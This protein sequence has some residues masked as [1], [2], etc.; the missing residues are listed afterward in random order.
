[1]DNARNTP[2]E[3]PTTRVLIDDPAS[4]WRLFPLNRAL[5][6]YQGDLA[7]PE[8]SNQTIRVVFAHVTTAAGKTVKLNRL[9]FSEWRLNADGQID[10]E[11]EMQDIVKRVDPVEGEIDHALLASVPVTDDDISAIKRCLGLQDTSP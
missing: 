6:V 1:M 2:D 7:I 9:E 4:G 11:V 5:L 3:L 10:Q 8:L